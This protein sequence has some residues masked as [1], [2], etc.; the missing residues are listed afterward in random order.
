MV[1]PKDLCQSRCE[2]CDTS[3]VRLAGFGQIDRAEHRVR[4]T[5]STWPDVG[6]VHK[7]EPSLAHRATS[8]AGS[9]ELESDVEQL[10]LVDLI[11]FLDLGR[12]HF[13]DR[14]VTRPAQM[15]DVE[16]GG[17]ATCDK[18]RFE[19]AGAAR[20][21]RSLSRRCDRLNVAGGVRPI[22]PSHIPSPCQGS[23]CLAG[24]HP[25]SRR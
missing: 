14:P 3:R 6:R 2:F 19:E 8:F 15:Q 4:V 22:P 18:R 16:P 1:S 24:L 7:D 23:Q 10:V 21:Y 13:V 5:S 12:R 25:L 17:A 9:V 11:G 20:P